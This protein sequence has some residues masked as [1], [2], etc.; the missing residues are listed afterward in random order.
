MQQVGWR[1]AY[2]ITVAVGTAIWWT[3]ILSI[4]RVMQWFVWPGLPETALIAFLPSDI[5]FLIL[6]PLVW[7][8][9][10]TN[11]LWNG[12][13]YAL[14]SATLLTLTLC[15]LTRGAWLGA[16]LM[17]FISVC[18][19]LVALP[20]PFPKG[21]IEAKH[22]TP[23][24]NFLK[25]LG[26]TTVMWS[27]FLYLLPYAIVRIEP[28]VGT[29]PLPAISP[30]LL[31]ILFWTA[32]CTGIYCGLIFAMHGEGTP[33]PL[34]ATTRFVVIGPYRYIR[35]PM[36]AL[37]I[38][39]GVLVAGLMRSPLVLAYA[40]AGGV[41]WHLLAR[42]WEEADLLQRFGEDYRSYRNDV[43]NWIPRLKPYP[44]VLLEKNPSRELEGGGQGETRT[45]TP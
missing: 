23:L 35:N 36:A 12:H 10:Q 45:L 16:I 6:I 9:R 25:T 15:T 14:H 27:V 28:I 39:Q 30:V 34:D 18:A 40:L 20:L 32:G 4:P 44:Q 17:L 2:A 37:G 33:L 41:A 19:E 13:R 38:F 31:W 43:H 26:Q 42:P 11:S 5:V 24:H 21:V 29:A 7:T 8:A 22:R 1:T 3:L